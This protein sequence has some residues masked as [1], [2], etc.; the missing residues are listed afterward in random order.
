[1]TVT[2]LYEAVQHSAADAVE[3]GER[4]WLSP[5]DVVGATGW[6]LKPEGLCREQLCVPLPRD[7]SWRDASGR[8]DLTAFAAAQGRAVVRDEGHHAWAFAETSSARREALRSG[9]AP[10]FE[11]PDLDGN[12]H[13]LSDHLGRKVFLFTYGS[14]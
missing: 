6:A 8:V 1:V 4:L 13:R 3:D 10:D 2:V 9:R 14:Y 12:R 7:G 11:L 5:A